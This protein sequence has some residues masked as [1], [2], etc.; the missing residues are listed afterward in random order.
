ML[1]AIK[2]D[3]SRYLMKASPLILD[4]FTP[5][6]VKTFFHTPMKVNNCVESMAGPG[7]YSPNYGPALVMAS[8]LEHQFMHHYIRE[9]GGAYGA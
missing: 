7:Y 2:R 4:P 1:N 3:N 9:K 6:Y 8:L 5:K